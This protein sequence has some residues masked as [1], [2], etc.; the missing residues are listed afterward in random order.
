MLVWEYPL[1]RALHPSR[2]ADLLAH[3]RTYSLITFYTR[4]REVAMDPASGLIRSAPAEVSRGGGRI[5]ASRSRRGRF[6]ML[7][8]AILSAIARDD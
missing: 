6:W 8:P 2:S 4:A 5:Q 3:T 7:I 1:P